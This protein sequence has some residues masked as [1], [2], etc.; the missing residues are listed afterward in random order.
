MREVETEKSIRQIVRSSVEAYAQGFEDRHIKEADNPDGTINMKIHN[1]FI[2]ALGE[3]I[4]YYTALVRSL[5][6]SLGNMLEGMAIN[7]A[8]LF[9]Q[10]EKKVEGPL[11][12]TQTQKI[13]ELLESYK[14]SDDPLTPDSSH[15]KEVRKARKGGENR[16]THVSDYYL[17]DEVSQTH[18]LVELKIGGDLDIKKARSEKEAIFEQYAILSNTLGDKASIKCYFATAYNRFGEDEEWNQQRVLQFFSKDELL[19]GKDFWNF[20][21]CSERGYKVVID[22]YRKSSHLIKKALENIK[23]VYLNG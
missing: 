18:Y 21:C 1:V 3:E 16:K 14:N 4:Q 6:S 12:S 20:V 13:A 5:D 8:K 22:E 7:I 15:Y 9:F 2:S 19:I 23:G 10:V 17:F 11:F